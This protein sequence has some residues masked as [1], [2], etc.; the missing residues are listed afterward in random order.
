MISRK[1]ARVLGEFYATIFRQSRTGHRS[2]VYPSS[3]TY[4]TV[5]TQNL[6]DFL[7]DQE[8]AS[9]FCNQARA[10][11][12]YSDTRPLKDFIM[13]LH[14]GE[15]QCNATQNWTWE[16]RQR[17]GQKYL[18]E[19]AEDILNH[20]HSE[21]GSYYKS[22]TTEELKTLQGSLELDGYIYQNSRLLA[23]E[24]DV[25]DVQEEVGILEALY[26]SL[27][28]GNKETAFHH[29]RLS[30]EH[31][32]AQRW[33]DAISNSRKF[34]ECVLQEVAATY[35]VRS[36]QIQLAEEVYTRPV[37]LRDYL[38][39]EGLIDTKEKEAVAKVYGLLSHTGSHP[40]MA[41]N[42]QA[43]LLRHLG[44]T[45]SQFVMLRLQGSLAVMS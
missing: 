23:S 1:T 35:S 7:Y 14:T 8:Y 19:L 15:T 21:L 18:A 42:D 4:Y 13:Q 3:Y 41:Q 22:N 16:Q 20:W 34:L 9:W 11:Q 45:F 44:L 40:Y 26:V 32:L 29:L 28:L 25:L 31:Y 43:R 27:G 2:N 30:E 38:E 17:L 37:L 39:H 36:K 33:D 12:S 24:E 10:I 6:Y 5:D